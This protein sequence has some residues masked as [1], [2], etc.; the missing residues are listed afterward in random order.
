MD[1]V[2]MSDVSAATQKIKD[3]AAELHSAVMDQGQE[4]FE[5]L[6]ETA[7]ETIRANPYRSVA[8]AF[9]VGALVG[10]CLFKR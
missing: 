6:C 5:T 3:G 4:K 1:E 8:I 2:Q 9:G 7:D 10:I